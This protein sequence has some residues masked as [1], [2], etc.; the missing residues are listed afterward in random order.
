M[1]QQLLYKLN[2][3]Y[4][5]QVCDHGTMRPFDSTNFRYPVSELSPECK[6]LL[7]FDNADDLE[8]LRLAWPG[9]SN[10]CVLITTRDFNA[11]HGLAKS[12]FH[13]QPFDQ[14]T[15]SSLLL[16]LVGIDSSSLEYRSKAMNIV[17]TLGGLPLALNQIAGFI[18]ERKLPLQD[19]LPLYERNAPKISARQT[20]ISDYGHTLSTL[21]IRIIC[22]IS[23]PFAN[24]MEYPKWC[25]SK[26]LG[27]LKEKI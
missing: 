7:I 9:H 27:H 3:G 2:I 17:E 12:G 11:A 4:R 15:G 24:R 1:L 13:L 5:R 19:F 14:E 26:D 21:V 8:I 20:V 25:S 23:L 18:S 6:W 22:S 10:G 16:D